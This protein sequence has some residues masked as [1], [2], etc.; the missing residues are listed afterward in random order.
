MSR[1]PHVFR[2]GM[3]LG[4]MGQGQVGGMER[5]RVCRG[6]GE[7]ERGTWVC[8]SRQGVPHPHTCKTVLVDG[9]K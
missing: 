5:V 3:G 1:D 7:Q 4:G 6:Q 9:L 2:H 8:G